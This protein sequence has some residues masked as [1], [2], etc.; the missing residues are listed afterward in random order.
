L[1]LYEETVHT[2]EFVF[3]L[4]QDNYFELFVDYIRNR[5]AV[6]VVYVILS[7]RRLRRDAL[8]DGL[9]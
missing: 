9:N 3:L 1:W 5:E 2:G 7:E 6:Y 4:W 8:L